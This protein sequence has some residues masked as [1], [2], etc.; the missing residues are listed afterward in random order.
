ME[1]RNRNLRGTKSCLIVANP[2]RSRRTAEAIFGAENNS[3]AIRTR[4]M[5]R[6]TMSCAPIQ[7][8]IQHLLLNKRKKRKERKTKEFRS[9]RRFRKQLSKE[10]KSDCSV[11]FRLIVQI[12][13]TEIEATT[14]EKKTMEWIVLGGILRIG[15]C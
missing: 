3:V 9:A 14:K 4:H 5:A 7:R 15:P 12:R 6:Q 13:L 11:E 1:I 10:T 8:K 2:M